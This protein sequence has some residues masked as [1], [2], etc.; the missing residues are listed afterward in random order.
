VSNG[1]PLICS[2]LPNNAARL[3]AG[4][5]KRSFVLWTELPSKL[6]NAYANNIPANSLNAGC[7]RSPAACRSWFDSCCCSR[8]WPLLRSTK[9]TGEQLSRPAIAVGFVQIPCEDHIQ[10]SLGP[11]V[12]LCSVF[13]RCSAPHSATGD[14]GSF[15]MMPQILPGNTQLNP[16]CAIF[17]LFYWITGFSK[18]FLLSDL[19]YSEQ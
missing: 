3:L 11:M 17:S 4:W 1:N 18:S 12:S 15:V 7:W 8:F 13:L 9:P 5:P 2:A 16:S 19:R 10:T 6:K 14:C